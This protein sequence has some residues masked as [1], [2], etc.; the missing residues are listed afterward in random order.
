M[1]KRTATTTLALMLLGGGLSA[2]AALLLTLASQDLIGRPGD[3]LGWGFILDNE[4]AYDLSVIRI[5]ADGTLFGN[6]GASALGDFTDAVGVWSQAAGGL[7]VAAGGFYTGT[8]LGT[9][10]ATFTLKSDA[11]TDA[12][13]VTGRIYLDYESYSQGEFVN[14]GF[15]TAQYGG[16]DALASVAVPEPATTALL[17]M[18]LAGLAWRRTARRAGRP[19]PPH[20]ARAGRVLQPRPERF[21]QPRVPM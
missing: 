10:L 1:I 12:D 20:R 3:T 11:P 8:A 9:A 14:S 2:Q 7:N 4:T 6:N 15:L 5:Y 18:G 13:P 19:V 17:T 21:F 16:Q